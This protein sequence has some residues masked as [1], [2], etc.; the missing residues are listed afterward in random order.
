M[1]DPRQLLIALNAKDDL[2]RAAVCRLAQDPDTW[3]RATGRPDDLASRLGLPRAQLGKAL[4][5]PARAAAVAAAEVARAEELGA[6]VITLLD[7]DYP[8]SLSDL[9]LPP[10]VLYV[11]GEIPRAPGVA[12]VGSRKA[13][14]YGVEAAAF[15]GRSLAEAGLAVISGFARGVDSAAHR[16]ALTAPGGRTVAVLG[17]GLDIPYP[18]SHT[19]LGRRIVE[20]GARLSEFPLGWLPRPWTFPIRNR[21]IAALAAGTVVVE[22]ARRSGSLITAHHALELGREVLAVP[23][24]I[25]DEKAL[26]PNGLIRDGATLVQHPQDV[27]DAL[28]L[29]RV[30]LGGGTSSQ[31]ALPIAAPPTV[32]AETRPLPG[33][34]AGKLLGQL[35]PGRQ[36]SPDDLA[37]LTGATMDQVLGELLELELQGWLRR[38]PGP[39]YGRGG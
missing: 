36:R 21:L 32:P 2:D 3:S 7:D 12:I 18:K 5:V 31:A 26:G 9:H 33:G 29:G 10:P 17:C 14:D 22:A 20:A 4:Q 27:L 37:S 38:H 30:R 6:R 39:L 19:Q 8:P 28:G 15:L 25:F 23:G 1:P 13:T 11:Q 24:R 35:P 34:L 16:G